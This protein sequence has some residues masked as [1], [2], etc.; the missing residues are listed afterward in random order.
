[1]NGL[2]CLVLLT[3]IFFQFKFN[4]T[5]DQFNYS[6]CSLCHLTI[7]SSITSNNTTAAAVLSKNEFAKVNDHTNNKGKLLRIFMSFTIKQ[8]ICRLMRFGKF[9]I[10]LDTRIRRNVFSKHQDT[11]K[12]HIIQSSEKASFNT[13]D[14]PLRPRFSSSRNANL[15]LDPTQSKCSDKFSKICQNKTKIFRDKIILEFRKSLTESISDE[16]NFYH[17]MYTSEKDKR[18]PICQIF[19]AK[20]RVLRK[21]D[22]PFDTN[23]FSQLFPK[24]KLFGK[25]GTITYKSCAIISSAGSLTKSGLGHFIGKLLSH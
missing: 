17:V 18:R 21:K 5:S 8:I 9:S 14:Y 3:Y 19:D 24:V 23:G 22:K 1:M 25:K 10:F 7:F 13:S 12:K 15:P 11:T 2:R 4:V 6:T 16:P 20:V